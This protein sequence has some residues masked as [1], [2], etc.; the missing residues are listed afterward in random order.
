MTSDG[1]TMGSLSERTYRGSAV[2]R[3]VV[4]SSPTAGVRKAGL[5]DLLREPV[6]VQ[7]PADL[8]L[9]ENPRVQRP[10]AAYGDA[11][12]WPHAAVSLTFSWR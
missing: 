8:L 5:R 11:W 6:G 12:G 10:W 9:A 1:S 3:R 7:Q 4:G 2:N